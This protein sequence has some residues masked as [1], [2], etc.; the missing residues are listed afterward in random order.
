MTVVLAIRAVNGIVLAADRQVTYELGGNISFSFKDKKIVPIGKNTFI[1]FSGDTENTG[2]L[3]EL[4]KENSE[5]LDKDL[6]K[7]L[8]ALKK[9]IG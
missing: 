6:F 4:L 8:D 5:N 3:I 1:G 7:A 9:A 2:Q